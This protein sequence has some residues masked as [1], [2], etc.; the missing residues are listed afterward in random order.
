MKKERGFTGDRP[1][2]LKLKKL[3]ED[4]TLLKKDSYTN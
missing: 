4:S 2:Y 1:A 3:S